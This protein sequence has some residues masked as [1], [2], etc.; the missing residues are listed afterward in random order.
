[1]ARLKGT[2]VGLPSGKCGD[3]VYRIRYGVPFMYKAC[4]DFHKS[5]SE[6]SKAG[7]EKMTPMSEFGSIVRSIPEL[8]IIWKKSKVKAKA[9]YHKIEKFNAKAFDRKRPTT[10]NKIV[11]DFGFKCPIN[12]IEF[13]REGIYIRTEIGDFG[14]TYN[15][16]STFTAINVVCVY[17]PISAEAKYFELFAVRKDVGLCQ[18]GEPIEIKFEFEEETKELVSGYKK[19]IIY[20]ELIALDKSGNPIVYSDDYCK[21]FELEET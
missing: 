10:E 18:P 16:I 19:G 20:F 17:E 12:Q 21:E 9:A 13:D 7:R 4:K 1:M 3:I 8:Y 14:E 2:V 6:E 15:L 11:P 5:E